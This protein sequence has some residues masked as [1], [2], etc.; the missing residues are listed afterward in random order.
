MVRTQGH[1]FLSSCFTASICRT[2][3]QFFAARAVWCV[4]CGWA[5]RSLIIPR[6]HTTAR[7]HSQ[8]HTPKNRLTFDDSCSKQRKAHVHKQNTF[9]QDVLLL[10][11]AL[12]FVPD[13]NESFFIHTCRTKSLMGCAGRV[14]NSSFSNSNF[15]RSR[16]CENLQDVV[17]KK[18]RRSINVLLL[19][20]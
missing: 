5:K 15:P 3:A 9:A 18:W 19:F 13:A 8:T 11:V 12:C 16:L 10:H 20:Q 17:D 6:T 4:R 14:W 7:S 2:P 1:S